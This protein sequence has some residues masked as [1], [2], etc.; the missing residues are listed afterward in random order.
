MLSWFFRK[1]IT[2][3]NT[4]RFYFSLTVAIQI[5]VVSIMCHWL[6]ASFVDSVAEKKTIEELDLLRHEINEYFSQKTVWPESLDQITE[7]IDTCDK[8][9]HS[10]N[11]N[12]Q[13]EMVDA[14]GTPYTL[15]LRGDK[16]VIISYGPD[17]K[18]GG[19]GINEDLYSDSYDRSPPEPTFIQFLT[20]ARY[21]GVVGVSL[22]N[23]LLTFLIFFFTN[24]PGKKKTVKL[25]KFVMFNIVFI[26]I[27]W[28]MSTWK[29]FFATFPDH[30]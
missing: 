27:I 9:C 3:S 2:L 1:E 5:A 8:C 23:G 13:G 28:K 21:A 12:N 15:V 14:W 26:V 19:I 17:R 7:Q 20:H 16:P 29:A 4:F 11:F 10:Y 22:L 6:N 30:H 24:K 25:W 18:R